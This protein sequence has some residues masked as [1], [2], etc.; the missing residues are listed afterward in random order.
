MVTFTVSTLVGIAATA[1]TT[2]II[3]V[4]SA[5]TAS[6]LVLGAITVGLAVVGSV[7]AKAIADPLQELVY[8]YVF[9]G[10]CYVN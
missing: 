6:V 5:S 4:I 8:T 3:G 7:I 10:K 1:L 9:G 2:A